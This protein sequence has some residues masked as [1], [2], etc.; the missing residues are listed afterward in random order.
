MGGTLVGAQNPTWWTI[1]RQECCRTYPGF[2]M[3]ATIETIYVEKPVEN[4]KLGKT[5]T[6]SYDGRR[7]L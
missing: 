2:A 6:A 7:G 1:E 4:A 5:R 3:A